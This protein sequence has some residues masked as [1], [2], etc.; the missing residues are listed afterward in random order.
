[1]SRVSMSRVSMSRVSMARVS[2]ARV[3]MSRVYILRV[4]MSLLIDYKND[5]DDSSQDC[6]K[7]SYCELIFL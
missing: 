7:T 6:H 5:W 3:S 4:S 1:M 2:M